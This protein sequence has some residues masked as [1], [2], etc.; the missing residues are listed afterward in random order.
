MAHVTL[1]T[2]KEYIGYHNQIDTES[3]KVWAL[4]KRDRILKKKTPLDEKKQIIF[5]L[6]HIPEL[7]ALYG[8]QK[9]LKNP[10]PEL[11]EFAAIAWQE[12][13][14]GIL[15]GGMR[16]LLGV[17]FEAPPLIMSGLGGGGQNLRYQFVL[18]TLGSK[19]IVKENMEMLT[20]VIEADSKRKGTCIEDAVFRPNFIACTSLVS[21]DV[22]VGTHIE[23]LIA[24]INA[25]K[26]ILRH[27]YLVVNTHVIEDEEIAE[28]LQELESEE[29]GYENEN[30]LLR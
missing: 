6:A 29:N 30:P 13:Q 19:N 5:T 27:H 9:Y 7:K 17:E 21:H 8:I 11:A 28:Y 16:G 20:R 14:Q 15:E 10:D 23:R 4:E 22:A 3:K 1:E 25:E 24:T 18:T 26:E 12:C 2:Q